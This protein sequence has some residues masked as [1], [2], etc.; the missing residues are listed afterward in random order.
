MAKP[1]YEVLK[2]SE[3]DTEVIQFT[4]EETEG[5][6]GAMQYLKEKL[7]SAP[8]LPFANFSKDAKLSSSK[9]T[10]ALNTKRLA[11]S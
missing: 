11:A 9:Q 4:V 2:H 1:L 8:E 5:I 10:T 6:L 3:K 7:L